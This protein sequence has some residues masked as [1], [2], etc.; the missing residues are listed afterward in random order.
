MVL[1]L[2]LQLV[3]TGVGNIPSE[4]NLTCLSRKDALAYYVKVEEFTA[5]KSFVDFAPE[6]MSDIEVDKSVEWKQLKK[7]IKNHWKIINLSFR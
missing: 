4:R 1:S 7:E 3:F 6:M 5:A 2:P